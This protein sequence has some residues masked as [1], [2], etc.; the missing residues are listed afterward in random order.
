MNPA[1]VRARAVVLFASLA[2][3]IACARERQEP[4]AAE[5]GRLQVWVTFYPTQYFAERIGAGRID[6]ILPLPPDDDPVFWRPGPEVIARY[7]AADLVVLNGAGFER[8]VDTASL[9]LSRVVETARAIDG[10]LMRYEDAITHRHGPAGEHSHEGVDGHTWVDPV[11]AKAQ[12]RAILSALQRA[13]PHGAAE[14]ERNFAALARD[15]DDLDARIRQLAARL[16]GR[17]LLASH[18]A[19][20][21][22]KRRYALDLDS[23]DFNPE[24]MPSDEALAALRDD[25]VRRPARLLLWESPPR[26]EV[27]ERLRRDLGLH[28]VEFSPC[29]RPPESAPGGPSDYLAVMRANLDRLSVAIDGS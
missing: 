1:D 23:L 29:E 13:L 18:P 4:A 17:R 19:Y 25:L 27:A 6:V 3:C 11:N 16:E 5:P 12:A 8:W 7:Q 10:E 24:E 14:L 9:P 21:Y 20:Q 22:L 15:L 28:S 2:S 26:D